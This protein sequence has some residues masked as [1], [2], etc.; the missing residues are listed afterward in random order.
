MQIKYKEATKLIPSIIK[1]PIIHLIDE[2][3]KVL[4]KCL[5]GLGVF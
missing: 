3:N 2:F 5:I 1:K 4:A